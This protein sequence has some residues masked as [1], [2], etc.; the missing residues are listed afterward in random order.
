MTLRAQRIVTEPLS[1]SLMSDRFRVHD[2]FH[3][4][5]LPAEWHTVR[6]R[7]PLRLA[8]AADANL[9][10]PQVEEHAGGEAAVVPNERTGRVEHHVV[11]GVD[12]Q[13]HGIPGPLPLLRISRIGDT[14]D[15]RT[16]FA[17]SHGLEHICRVHD[18][19]VRAVVDRD[20][21]AIRRQ[22]LEPF[23]LRGDQDRDEVD[24]SVLVGTNAQVIFLDRRVLNAAQ[25]GRPT[26]DHVDEPLFL[27]AEGERDGPQHVFAHILEREVQ[28]KHGLTE[29]RH[30]LRNRRRIGD[31][32]F[33]TR[34]RL[35][36]VPADLDVRMLG[37]VS[38]LHLERDDAPLHVWEGV[39]LQDVGAEREQIAEHR[40]APLNV[41]C[42][43]AVTGN[44]DEPIRGD[45]GR[46]RDNELLTPFTT[47]EKVFQ[48][49][50][51]DFPHGI[52]LRYDF[53]GIDEQSP[54]KYQSGPLKSIYLSGLF[55]HH[56]S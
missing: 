7:E 48:I 17:T 25:D 49:Q 32:Q 29:P 37:P 21:G 14:V 9:V 8:L 54:P 3:H 41:R 53:T 42:N 52:P 40:V 47:S 5:F 13:R 22:D 43:N 12:E 50:Q 16:H 34:I 19:L 30:L 35:P 11:L 26:S 44:A 45:D 4:L 23:A 55:H 39:F 31:A 1:L 33:C 36:L 15:D 24:V 56:P 2:L 10:E 20:P 46:E 51:R 38:L 6:T 27:P 28:G 18:D